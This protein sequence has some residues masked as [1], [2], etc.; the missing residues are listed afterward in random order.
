MHFK[1]SPRL[2]LLLDLY[3]LIVVVL[4]VGVSACV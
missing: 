3:A 1:A 4:M 2:A